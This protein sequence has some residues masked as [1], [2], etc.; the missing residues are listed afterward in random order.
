LI[1]VKAICLALDHLAGGIR[2]N[3]ERFGGG[4]AN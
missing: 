2:I 3:K 1:Q 4:K